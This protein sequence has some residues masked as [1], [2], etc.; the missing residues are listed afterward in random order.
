MSGSF[1]T[2]SFSKISVQDLVA[3]RSIVAAGNPLQLID[4][5]EPEEIAIAY[6]PGF[7]VLPLSEFRDWSVNIKERFDPQVETL[8]LCHHGQRSA[9]MCEWLVQQGFTQVKNIAGGIAAY[10]ESVDPTIAQY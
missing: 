8:V 1:S 5:R 7:E 9:Q 2:Q 6:I 3:R 10:S 4:V